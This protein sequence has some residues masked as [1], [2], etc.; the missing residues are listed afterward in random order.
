MDAPLQIIADEISERG[1]IACVLLDPYTAWPLAATRVN[2]AHFGLIRHAYIWSACERIMAAGGEIDLISLQSQ[3]NTSGVLNDVGGVAYLTSLFSHPAVVTNV[4][5]YAESVRDAALKREA[6]RFADEVRRV[7]Q[8]GTTNDI[9]AVVGDGANRLNQDA[10]R[11]GLLR[12]G[13][14]VGAHYDSISEI[15]DGKATRAGIPVNLSA[16]SKFLP[17]GYEKGRL[18]VNAG[19]PGMGKSYFSMEAAVVAALHGKRVAVFTLEMTRDQ[20]L[21]R[22]YAL[23]AKIPVA[24]IRGGQMN[25]DEWRAYADAMQT[26]DRLA[27]WIDDEPAVTVSYIHAQAALIRAIHGLDMIVVDYLQIMGA[28]RVYQSRQNEIAANIRGLKK[29]SKTLCVPVLVAAQIGRQVEQRANKRPMLSDLRE[30]GDIETDADVVIGQY[31]DVE[32]D[33]R[34]A[35]MT[36]Y[37]LIVLKNRDGATGTAHVGLFWNTG[38]FV[39]VTRREVNLGN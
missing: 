33:A 26:V 29:L 21:D 36:P 6:L 5:T 32:Q 17:L 3:L 9:L 39:D 27:L 23:L 38:Q 25:H 35:G 1:L 22:I 20:V 14:L 2:A 18:Y 16:L 24:K 31:S 15:S 12:V 28:E 19:R 37:E 7:A 4:L 10:A 11:G 30:S 8:E 34:G 13:D